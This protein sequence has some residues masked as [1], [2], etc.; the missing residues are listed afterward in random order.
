MMAAN[1][2]SLLKTPPMDASQAQ[3]QYSLG[4]KQALVQMMQQAALS[5]NMP[6]QG[7]IASP[8]SPLVPLMQALMGYKAKSAQGELNQ[9]YADYAKKQQDQRASA[10][11]SMLGGKAPTEKVDMN[12][13]MAQADQAIRSGVPK[14]IVDTYLSTAKESNKQP[15]LQSTSHGMR[16]NPQTGAYSD[17][18]GKPLTDE[19]VQAR[20]SATTKRS[21][22]WKDVGD[23]LVPV[24]NDTGEDV[25]GIKPKQKGMTPTQAS[26]KFTD[27]DSNLLAAFAERGVSLPT[28]LRSKEQIS[29]TLKGLRARNPDLNEDQIAEKVASGQIDFGV[30]KKET[31]VAAGIGGKIAYAENEIK[32]ITPLVREASAKVPRGSFVPW[33][34]LSQYTD[35]QLSDPNLKELK[36]YMNTLSNAYDMLAARGGTDMEK[37]KHNREMFDTADSPQA[38]EAALKAVENEARISGKAAAVSVIPNRRRQ[39]E[40]PPTDLASAAL[41]ELKRRGLK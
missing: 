13:A 40:S 41:A 20:M 33:N 38:L 3:D 22:E 18:D 14:E 10:L 6:Q 21:V 19:E 29:N 4:Q 39:E 25:P 9:G 32:Q 24:W 8:T 15:S 37:R 17:A 35:A 36:L 26:S 27:G 23:K 5:Q 1:P 16:F 34:K 11:A 28:G 7:A 31:Q 30:E 2:F 12:T